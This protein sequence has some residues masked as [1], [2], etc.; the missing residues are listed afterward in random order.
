MVN[1]R[2]KG[3]E[4]GRGVLVKININSKCSIMNNDPWKGKIVR[5]YLFD[6]VL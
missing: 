6:A 2:G 3:V 5:K 1:L 4:K